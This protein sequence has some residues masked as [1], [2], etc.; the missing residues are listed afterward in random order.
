M[1]AF[2]YSVQREE[3]R[4]RGSA[5]DQ[6]D[7]SCK[8][9]KRGYWNSKSIDIVTS[10]KWIGLVDRCIS[11]GSACYFSFCLFGPQR[12]IKTKPTKI[13]TLGLQYSELGQELG[14]TIIILVF[15]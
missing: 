9:F 4:R 5:S 13:A 3:S 12:I 7:Q 10:V 6:S 8:R 11:G 14:P 1:M 15:W 2:A